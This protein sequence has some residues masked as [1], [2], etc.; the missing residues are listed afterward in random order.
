[1][2]IPFWERRKTDQLTAPRTNP[3]SSYLPERYPTMFQ[4]TETG[5]DNLVT[6]ESFNITQRP[7]PEDPMT[8]SARLI[9]DDLAIMIEKEDTHYY[10]LAGAILLPG[11]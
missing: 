2:Q 5:I 7:L 3:S 1:M 10:L 4:K 11:F 9:Q 6:G 8:T